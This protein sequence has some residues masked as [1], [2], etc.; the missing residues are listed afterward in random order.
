MSGASTT[1]STSFVVEA[2]HPALAGHFPGNPVVPGVLILEHVVLAVEATIARRMRLQGLRQV[3]FLEP[4]LPGQSAQISLE[5]GVGMIS[6]R[7]TRNG[8]LIA[9]GLLELASGTQS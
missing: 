5:A 3:K 7:V 2:S 8:S 4:L 9:K 1:G 6:F